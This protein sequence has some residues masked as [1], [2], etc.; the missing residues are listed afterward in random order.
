M[1]SSWCLSWA[2]SS[3]LNGISNSARINGEL[4]QALSHLA[5]LIDLALLCGV[6]LFLE[7]LDGLS[8]LLPS[9]IVLLLNEGSQVRQI[10]IRLIFLGLR[11]QQ[12]DEFLLHLVKLFEQVGIV[13]TDNVLGSQFDLVTDGIQCVE[14]L[15]HDGNHHVKHDHRT[16][17]GRYD[18]ED[19]QD[20][21]ILSFAMVE[22][23]CMELTQSQEVLVHDGTGF[24]SALTKG[25]G[26]KGAVLVH[27]IP[28]GVEDV[29]GI[30]EWEE[31][32]EENEQEEDHVVESL[33]HQSGEESRIL[34]QLEE[35]EEL[36][37]HEPH[38]YCG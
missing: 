1:C 25:V 22:V 14:G 16:K 35:V 21:S 30:A 13:G 37:P 8:D 19:P 33:V 32:E 23:V 3:I 17:E 10:R 36:E 38:G 18:E 20:G 11:S 4:S 26:V 5:S 12:E 2:T 24:F 31:N 34:Y 15:S 29:D 6:H 9:S 27:D 28:L 7:D